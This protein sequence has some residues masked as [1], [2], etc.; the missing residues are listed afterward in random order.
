MKPAGLCLALVLAATPAAAA[1]GPSHSGAAAQHSA[2]KSAEAN[3]SV[4][5]AV[6]KAKKDV[7]T[8][9]IDGSSGVSSF[10]GCVKGKVP[11]AQRKT[12]GKCLVKAA[13]ADKKGHTAY[14]AEQALI[15]TSAPACVAPAL[16]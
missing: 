2:L 10:I 3:P 7:I 11:K 6:A 12:V 9:C 15:N 1:C 14:Q 4:E 13:L 8:P 5:A 16:P